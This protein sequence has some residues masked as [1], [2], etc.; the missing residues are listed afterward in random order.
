VVWVVALVVVGTVLPLVWMPMSSPIGW[1][2]LAGGLLIAFL[3]AAS[4]KKETDRISWRDEERAAPR[5]RLCG[6][7]YDEPLDEPGAGEPVG[8]DVDKRCS[9]CGRTTRESGV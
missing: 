6:R 7:R 8:L 9:E 4:I 3:I 2:G 1:V 5:C